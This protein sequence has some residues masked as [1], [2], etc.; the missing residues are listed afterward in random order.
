MENN[1]QLEQSIK[2]MLS[3]LEGISKFV[4]SSTKIALSNLP[5]DQ[6]ISQAQQ[7]NGIKKTI[8]D[9]EKQTQD[10]IKEL[11]RTLNL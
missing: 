7:L 5:K 11:K 6:I 2:E 1:K 4:E 3:G 10:Q 9:A 8:K